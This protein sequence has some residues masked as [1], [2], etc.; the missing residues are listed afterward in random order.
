MNGILISPSPGGRGKGRGKEAKIFTPIL[1]LPHQEGG[2]HYEQKLKPHPL[3]QGALLIKPNLRQPG[4]APLDGRDALHLGPGKCIVV[5]ASAV[6]YGCI[7]VEE[8]G[9][10]T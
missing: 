4:D 1:I 6:D 8:P 9:N 2:D 3:G 5:P 10:S 7:F